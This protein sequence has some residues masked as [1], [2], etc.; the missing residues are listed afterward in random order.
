MSHYHFLST[1][2]SI[3]N[4]HPKKKNSPVTLYLLKFL[5]LKAYHK[6]PNL[7]EISQMFPQT[8]LKEHFA[9]N[10]NN[11][12]SGIQKYLFV[13]NATNSNLIYHFESLA[14]SDTSMQQI[15]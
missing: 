8:F 7:F 2:P 13:R 9:P 5:F 3:M 6:I 15:R 14:C 4:H 12:G 10:K 11:V 1:P